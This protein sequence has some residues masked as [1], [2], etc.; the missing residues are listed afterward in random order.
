MKTPEPKKDRKTRTAIF[1]NSKGGVGKST[2][3]LLTCLGLAS[4]HKNASVELIDL[5]SQSTSSDS[6]QRFANH[7]FSVINDEHLFLASGS[8][9]NG[10]IV[11]H[12][13][14]EPRNS[15]K[16]SFLIFDSPAGSEPARSSF[17]LRCNLIFVPTSVSDADVH[18]TKKYLRSLQDLF[19]RQDQ[20]V[21]EAGSP[22]IVILPNM[23]DSR[24][25][26]NELRQIL[27]TEPA[28]YGKPLY[29]STVF[30]RAFRD[31]ENDTNVK[32]LMLDS[33][34]YVDWITSL[35]LNGETL[36]GAE[37]KLYQL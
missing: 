22:A 27:A 23:M 17:L 11:N 15:E 6:L 35:I 3:A 21:S 7:R 31:E 2:L 8:P 36:I 32:R 25:E 34:G 30:R 20:Q 26:Y 14:S 18:A 4:R 10:N 37:E 19:D 1:A 33:A 28:Y 24:E 29:F 12:I 16:D 9:N 13:D 5:D